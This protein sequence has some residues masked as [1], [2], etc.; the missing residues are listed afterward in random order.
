MN[1]VLVIL[2]WDL[3][4]S[5]ILLYTLYVPLA[6]LAIICVYYSSFCC[7]LQRKWKRE[8]D[9]ESWHLF[10][11]LFA[12]S[13]VFLV[14]VWVLKHVSLFSLTR[15][16]FLRIRRWFKVIVCYET[17]DSFNSHILKFAV[18]HVRV[19]CLSF[20][21]VRFRILHRFALL[22][23]VQTFTF[24]S[25]IFFQCLYFSSIRV[26]C[27]AVLFLLVRFGSFPQF[28]FAIHVSLSREC[29]YI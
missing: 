20:G 4:I 27:C 14:F 21:T 29:E 17:C 8:R 12:H 24:F 23:L 11:Y 6:M 19:L 3:G 10:I 16:L 7:Y 25:T 13:S 1:F 9:T 2:G 28:N 18:T 26:L 22:C 5:Y 15:A